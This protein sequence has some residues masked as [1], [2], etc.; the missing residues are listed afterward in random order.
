MAQFD[1][2]NTL[3]HHGIKGQKWGVRRFQNPDGTLTEE[4]KRHS[5]KSL[6][7]EIERHNGGDNKKLAR[8]A[9]VKKAI[10]DL[11]VSAKKLGDAQN[12]LDKF[13]NDWYSR[14]NPA[15][16]KYT[17][18]L[19]EKMAREYDHSTDEKD[20]LIRL[21]LIRNDDL[22]QGESFE[23][24]LKDHPK[25]NRRFQEAQRKEN[26][27]YKEHKE[28]IKNYTKELVGEYGNKYYSTS[29]GS[30]KFNYTI[31]SRVEGLLYAETMEGKRKGIP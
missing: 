14:K 6:A 9:Q 31:A 11:Q 19:A 22:D 2:W 28:A 3:A 26:A 4:G 25:A 12:E 29:F 17:R 15:Y 20:I 1:D 10:D 5:Q 30:Y 13:E 18:K 16:D 21:D 7:K 23:L 27:A 8:N 24:Y